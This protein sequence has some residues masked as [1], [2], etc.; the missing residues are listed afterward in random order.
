[1]PPAKSKAGRNVPAAIAVGVGLGSA[2][3]VSLYTFRPLF[4]GLVA[5]SVAYG[6]YE[7][8]SVLRTAAGRIVPIAP[9]VVGIGV[10]YTIAYQ[11][12]SQALA[13]GVLLTAIAL[14]AWRLVDG[15][16]R[17]DVA[18]DVSVSLWLLCYVVLLAG[19]A[20]LLA[21]PSDG[22]R[23]ATCLIATVVASDV[24]GFATGVFFGKHPLA[25]AISPKK[26]WE[27]LAGSILAC[28]VVGGILLA[29]LLHVDWWQGLVFGLAMAVTA[30]AGDLA[31][32][33][34]K[35]DLGVKDMGRLLP[36]HG[37]IMDRLDSMLFT[38]P[39]AYLLITAFTS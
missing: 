30:T 35:R 18:R 3:L 28:L 27:G 9:L 5:V 8:A 14:L 16:R 6:C 34:I 36:G 13:V 22:A 20:I 25:P 32:S 24:G 17:V 4:V 38:A 39:V 2:V 7:V 23:R 31:E 26:S 11:R 15:G 21:A 37:G 29:S 12:G 33:L 10:T 19:F 1:V